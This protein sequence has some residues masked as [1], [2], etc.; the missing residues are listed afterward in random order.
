MNEMQTDWGT[1]HF[2]PTPLKIFPLHFLISPE[3]YK[4]WRRIPPP[5]LPITAKPRCVCMQKLGWW[6]EMKMQKIDL[7]PVEWLLLKVIGNQCTDGWNKMIHTHLSAPAEG[8]S[9][10][11]QAGNMTE[12]FWLSQEERELQYLKEETWKTCRDSSLDD[13]LILPKEK[14]GAILEMFLGLK[15]K[16]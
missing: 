4:L 6:M 5:H 16:L 14:M 13:F 12:S 7:S 9:A 10:I 8:F 3:F 1:T 11:F 2:F 15:Y